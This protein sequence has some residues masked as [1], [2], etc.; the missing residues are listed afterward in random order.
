MEQQRISVEGSD[1]ANAVEKACEQLGLAGRHELEYEFDKEHFRNGADTVL[2]HAWQKDPRQLEAVKSA[3]DLVEGFLDRFGVKQRDIR[4]DEGDSKT[5]L[6]ISAGDE[7][8]I[9]I[10]QDGKNLDALQHVL[11]NAMMHQ[12]LDHKVVIDVEDYRSRREDRIREYAVNACRDALNA[13]DPI[14]LGPFNSYERRIIHLV[15]KGQFDDR[16]ASQ[17]MGPGKVRE[18]EIYRK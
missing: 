11:S 1:L 8:N 15:V 18:L 9:L 2:I 16:L 5:T 4:V 12:G 17:S 10:G 14:R 6:S 7:A 13:D 3:V